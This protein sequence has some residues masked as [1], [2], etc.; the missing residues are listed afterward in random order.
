MLEG[1]IG[2][3][4]FNNEFGRPACG[5]FR[6]FEQVLAGEVRGY[7]KPIMIA[8]GLGNIARAREQGAIPPGEAGRAR[9]PGDADRPR[10]RRRLVDGLRRQPRRPRLRLG[11]ARTTPRCSAAARRSSTAAGSW[12]TTTRSCFIHDVGA[13]GLSNA[14]PELVNDGGRGGALRAAQGAQRRAGHVAARD[15]VQ[16]VAGALR[17][18]DRAPA[19][20]RV[21][22]DLRARALPLRGRRRGDRRRPPDRDRR[23]HFGNAPVDM[24]L[25][26]CSA[27]RRACTAT[28]RARARARP[29]RARLRRLRPTPS[30]A[31]C[32]AGGG[33]QELPDHHRRPLVGGLSRATRWSAPGRCRWPT[34]PSPPRAS[35][36]TGE[37]MAMGERTP[38]A[39][40]DAPASGRMAVGEALTNS[41][42]PASR[43]RRRQA[44]RQLDGRRRPP[45]R[46]RRLFDAVRRW[47]WS[48]ARR[49]ASRSRSA[50]IRCRCAPPGRR[51]RKKV[52]APLSLIVSAFAP[53]P[54][55]ATLTPQLRSTSGETELLL[56][57]LGRGQEPPRRLGLAQ[58]YAAR[59]A[60]SA[61]TSTIPR[62]S[63]ASSRHPATRCR[64]GL[65]LAYHDRSDGGL[66]ATAVRDGLRRA[67]VAACAR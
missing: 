28:S 61:R 3:A 55:C 19:A 43:A 31:C 27:S 1:P 45:R 60:S 37:A 41:P 46:G 62:C 63:A 4:A 25:R 33:Q 48:S 26:C 18:G 67:P 17:A 36:A 12:A 38:L 14:L 29:A 53:V 20:R 30:S 23:R 13:G 22:R 39:L 24:P 50:R 16:R 57:D 54:T 49:S 56:V 42:P 8:G 66:F 5:Y 40:L 34:A 52:T 35:R 7:H 51:R 44:L 11:A 32:A 64:D 2:G 59:S 10:R 21:R 65:L 9:R 58:V 6:T 15:L 47:A